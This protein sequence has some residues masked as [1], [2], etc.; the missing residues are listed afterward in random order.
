MH[1]I[2][3]PHPGNIMSISALAAYNGRMYFGDFT[4][5]F[6][7]S[8]SLDALNANI[9]TL[10][11]TDADNI[12]NNDATR[13]ELN[14]AYPVGLFV[15]PIG[16]VYINYVDGAVRSL[17]PANVPIPSASPQATVAYITAT[18]STQTYTPGA[19]AT[20]PIVI[21]I[22]S[23]TCGREGC[24]FSFNVSLLTCTSPSSGCMQQYLTFVIVP[25]P[26]LPGEVASP[27]ILHITAPSIAGTILIHSV[28]S[29]FSGVCKKRKKKKK[30][31][32]YYK[33]SYTFFLFSIKLIVNSTTLLPAAGTSACLCTQGITGPI[34]GN[35]VSTQATTSHWYSSPGF[36][37]GISAAVALIILG[38]VL[39]TY[40]IF[41]NRRNATT[42]Q[43]IESSAANSQVHETSSTPTLTKPVEEIQGKKSSILGRR[44]GFNPMNIKGTNAPANEKD[45]N[46]AVAKQRTPG[47][48]TL[49]AKS[50]H[51]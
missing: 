37:G 50:P 16:L 1:P 25:G 22:S 39:S 41:R 46:N 5:G 26:T 17:P 47:S 29:T 48:Q 44:Q 30:F 12:N 4:L 32:Y 14:N 27:P 18:A 6:I 24:Q 9:I 31:L 45:G 20:A 33:I 42:A 19:A 23:S 49:V 40:F 7:R 11:Y 2:P 3:P 35:T 43:G 13:I 34:S 8:V 21:D 36:I 10:S 51:A 38:V 15:L 28:L